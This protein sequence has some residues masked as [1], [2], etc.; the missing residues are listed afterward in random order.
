MS[1]YILTTFWNLKLNS[2]ACMKMALAQVC[3]T[4]VTFAPSIV[5][6]IKFTLNSRNVVEINQS[7]AR[8]VCASKTNKKNNC[9]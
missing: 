5:K 9:Y 1:F 2:R 3:D 4:F 6:R 8:D 7:C